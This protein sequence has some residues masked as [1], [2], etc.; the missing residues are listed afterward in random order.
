MAR[1][2]SR[3]DRFCREYIK[4]L[5][6]KRAAAIE[7]LARMLREIPARKA[8][9]HFSSGI[10]R[11]GNE[12]QA[13][14]RA[15]IDAANQSN[16]SLY[17]VDARG[18]LALP[19]LGTASTSGPTGTAA[20]SGEAYAAQMEGLLDSRE[21]LAGLAR[22]TGGRDFYDLN[23][24]GYIFQQVQE[25][26][27][28]YYLLGYYTSNKDADGKFRRV[29]VEVTRSTLDTRGGRLR[30]KHRPGYFAPRDFGRMSRG[31]RERQLVHA[32]NLENS[33]VELPLAIETLYFRLPEEDNRRSG[34]MKSTGTQAKKS[35]VGEQRGHKSDLKYFVVLSAKIPGPAVPFREKSATLQTEFNFLWRVLDR[36]GHLAAMLHDTLPVKLD[37][38]SYE[39]SVRSN[40]LYQGGI[41]LRPGKYNLRVVVREN[42]SGKIGTFEQTLNLSEPQG[43]DLALS[44]V[45]VS[46]QLV[47]L[48]KMPSVTGKKK[49]KIWNPL[50][51]KDRQILPSVTRV[52]FD[53]Q[54]LYVYLEA[55]GVRPGTDTPPQTG[56]I[57]FQSNRK[58]EEMGPFEASTFGQLGEASF[59]IEVPLHEIPPGRY[60]LQVNVLDLGGNRAAF[61]RLP[62]AVLKS[63]RSHPQATVGK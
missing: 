30:V 4:D 63:G 9:M 31:D 51:I 47:D 13:Q 11:T 57:F 12:N 28:S 42:A 17:A 27:S 43:S 33:F 5:N 16:V 25:E 37:P 7:S 22:D 55:Y 21:T 1:N 50:V 38:G 60:Q 29:R 62:I 20:Y 36:H 49:D 8:V 41:T 56:V 48:R 45:V 44:S 53:N 34:R 18:L 54:K 15:T 26:N 23:D 35:R 3:H 46:N 14:L 2:N 61:A 52:F 58:V 24:F 59:L 19:P 32:L 40:L 10:T 6:G 39:Q